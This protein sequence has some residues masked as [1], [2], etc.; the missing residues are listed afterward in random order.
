MKK[1]ELL[2]A[3]SRFFIPI[4]LLCGVFLLLEVIDSGFISVIHLALILTMA[5]LL[6]LSFCRS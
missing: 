3:I 1:D 4:L 6:F 5:I 2:A